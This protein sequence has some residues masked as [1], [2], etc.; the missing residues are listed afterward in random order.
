VYILVERQSFNSVDENDPSIAPTPTPAEQVENIKNKS[1]G[2]ISKEMMLLLQTDS[3]PTEQSL[4]S[5]P[6]EQ[7]QQ[8]LVL[9][10][11]KDIEIFNINTAN[12][13]TTNNEQETS[14]TEAE[15]QDQLATQII[16]DDLIESVKRDSHYRLAVGNFWRFDDYMNFQI[17]A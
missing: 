10:G 12:N 4:Q 15:Y 1:F 7:H 2:N 14:Y 17:T 9:K 5:L 13:D 6:N 3:V 16:I 11:E 8:Q